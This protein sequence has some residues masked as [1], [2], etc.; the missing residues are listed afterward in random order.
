MLSNTSPVESHQDIQVENIGG[1]T[2]VDESTSNEV[3]NEPGAD[4]V[5][6]F[7]L[8]QQQSENE[9]DSRPIFFC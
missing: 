5:S 6:L 2:V 1:N 9:E 8:V 3:E 7:S 4:I